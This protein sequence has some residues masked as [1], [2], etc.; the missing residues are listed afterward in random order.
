M[1]FEE[2]IDGFLLHLATERG[3]SVNYQ[4]LIQRQLEDFATWCRREKGWESP[5]S[6]GLDD[7]GA[8]LG[9]RKDGGLASS[10]LRLVAIALR[11]FYRRLAALG[12]I[13][14]D[15]AAQLIPARPDKTL[16]ETLGEGQVRHFLESIPVSTPM[17]RRDRAIAELLY[18]SGLRVSELVNARL[19]HLHLEEAFVRVTGKGN[20]TRVVPVGGAARTAIENWLLDGRTSFA[21][22]KSPSTIFLSRRGARLTTER[23]RQILLE[24]ARAAGLDWNLYPHLFRHSFATHLLGRGAD[25]RVIQEM[26]GHADISTT[27]IYTHVDAAHLRQLHRNFHPRA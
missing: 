12:Q 9:S 24:R 27:Q 16:P 4:T 10:S 11:I 18:S 15:P 14:T 19:E 26:L 23:V 17:D 7:L 5:A 25:L 3:L 8:Y 2:A 22:L 1:T 6:A 13:S 20:K 21:N